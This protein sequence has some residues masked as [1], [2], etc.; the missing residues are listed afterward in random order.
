MLKEKLLKVVSVSF[1]RHQ[2]LGQCLSL[3]IFLQIWK[4]E[5]MKIDFGLLTSLNING[6]V[7][8]VEYHSAEKNDCLMT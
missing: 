7:Q 3:V 4:E 2:H 8:C 5:V 6:W 1:F